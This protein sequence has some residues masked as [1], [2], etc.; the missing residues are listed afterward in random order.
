MRYLPLL[1]LSLA[2]APVSA[3][4]WPESESG[5]K[6]REDLAVYTRQF[7]DLAAP[8][9]LYEGKPGYE[10]DLAFTAEFGRK[11]SAYR[12]LF[13]WSEDDD[14]PEALTPDKFQLALGKV[15]EHGEKPEKGLEWTCDLMGA[16]RGYFAFYSESK[17][18]TDAMVQLHG[19]NAGAVSFIEPLVGAVAKRYKE[20]TGDDIKTALTYNLR[21]RCVVEGRRLIEKPEKTV[22][23]PPKALVKD[24]TAAAEYKDEELDFSKY[25]YY[26]FYYDASWQSWQEVASRSKKW[27]GS[28]E[29]FKRFVL[30]RAPEWVGCFI[31]R[32]PK[33]AKVNTWTSRAPGEVLRHPLQPDAA[34]LRDQK[35]IAANREKYC[36]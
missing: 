6:A 27:K 35:L 20:A 16:L 7:R 28:P 33:G 17:G 11:F 24:C 21:D 3:Q 30:C 19:T 31:S 9:P 8:P 12:D 34:K 13:L 15:S 25:D 29:S 32:A 26:A 1:A 14:R 5:R 18:R 23:T 4:S 2:C 22:M 10:K 36:R